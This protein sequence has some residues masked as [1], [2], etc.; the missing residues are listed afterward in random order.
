[1]EEAIST[2][3]AAR[4]AL[5]NKYFRDKFFNK[6]TQLPDI[7]FTTIYL[8]VFLDKHK[9][10]LLTLTSF[11]LRDKLIVVYACKGTELRLDKIVELKI[12]LGEIDW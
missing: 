8:N 9:D 7:I 6:T 5:K 2:R 1:M 10:G 11:I 4:S 3:H 12:V